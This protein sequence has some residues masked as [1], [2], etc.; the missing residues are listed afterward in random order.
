VATTV[1]RLEAIL[2]ADTRQFDQAMGKSE[3]RM[4]KMGKAAALGGLAIAGGLAVGLKKSVDAALESEKA[5]ARLTSAMDQAGI[6]A[7]KRAAA[8]DAISATSKRAALDDEALSDVYAKLVRTT[9]SVTAATEGMNLAADIARARNISLEAAAKGVERAYNGSAAGLGKF[10]VEIEKVTTNVDTANLAIDAQKAAMK[11]LSGAQL[12]AAKGVLNSLELAAKD[13]KAKDKQLQATNAL[14]DATKQFAGSSEAYGKTAAGA[15]ER[16]GIAVENLQEKIGAKLLPILAKL[17]ELSLKVIESIET[18]WPKIAAVI[19]PILERVGDAIRQ[20]TEDVQRIWEQHGETIMRVV[21]FAFNT[22]R[23]AIE[24][25]LK[26]IRGIVDVVMGL[27]TGDW[28]RAWGGLKGIVEGVFNAIKLL[29]MT[30][31]TV[32]GEL[33]KRIGSALK[34]AV[35]DGVTGLASAVW[36]LITRIGDLISDGAGAIKGWGADVGGWVKQGV[37]D[38]ITGIG[39]AAWGMVNNIW[40]RIEERAGQV[41]GWGK[42]IGEWVKD[43]VVD[44]LEGVGVAIWN[45]LKAAWDWAMDKVKSLPGIGKLIGDAGDPNYNPFIGTAGA[46]VGASGGIN[47]MGANPEMMPFAVGAQGLGLRVT[48]GLR[49]GAITANGTLSDHA[50]GK[51]LDVAGSAFSMGAFFDSLVGNRAVKQAFYDPKGSVFGGAWSSYREGGHSDHVHVATY[52]KGGWLKPG[53]TLAYNGTG[54]PE[55]VGGRGDIHL[56]FH[57]DMYGQ[58]PR[59]FFKQV[60]DGLRELDLLQTG[61]RVLNATPTL[62]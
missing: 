15:Q 4:S 52:D 10:G 20:F 13:A 56:H 19:M 36:G 60:R 24:N 59:Q 39:A 1:A 33:G 54:A 28:E 57:G 26:I 14:D 34:E 61:G 42:S 49:P 37:I 43:A 47:L 5:Q 8:N 17:M 45:K 23:A 22:I 50:R 35:I 55:R 48:S 51:A 30:A 27:L 12:E 18:N 53:L 3:G 7:A 41:K 2:G 6:S 21:T 40:E 31:L 58:P 38:G 9:G 46:V 29:L 25:T 44:G 11:G 62:S 16:F 32:W